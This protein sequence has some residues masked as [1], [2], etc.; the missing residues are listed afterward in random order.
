MAVAIAI[1]GIIVLN[2][3]Q[4]KHSFSS[5]QDPGIPLL[6]GKDQYSWPSCT[7]KFRSAVFDNANITYFLQKNYILMRW[8]GQLYWVLPFS[9]D[10][11]QDLL[12]IFADKNNYF[13]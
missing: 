2:F 4:C 9:K 1:A 6:K 7:N 5:K 13:D 8:E 12:N 10:F 3:C 11:L